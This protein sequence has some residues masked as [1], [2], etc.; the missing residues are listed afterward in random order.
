MKS[1]LLLA[2][3]LCTSACHLA[4]TEP[5]EP[6]CYDNAV[7]SCE[8][9]TNRGCTWC[10][11]GPNPS[12]GYCCES[13]ARCAKPIANQTEC[14]VIPSCDDAI[15]NSCGACLDRGCAWCPGE[16]RCHARGSD[17]TFPSCEGRVAGALE[18][19]ATATSEER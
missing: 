8:S 16:A 1:V 17:G 12:D 14:V 11:E 15:V 2:V 13:A 18:C 3:A 19:P 5:P 10:S 9:C 6:T 4:R 7:V